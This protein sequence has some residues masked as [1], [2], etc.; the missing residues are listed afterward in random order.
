MRRHFQFALPLLALT[1]LLGGCSVHLAPKSEP[2]AQA[3]AQE[4]LNALTSASDAYRAED[5]DRAADLFL[6][7]S[8]VSSDPVLSR[9]ALYG[10]A[11]SKRAMAD[12]AEDMAEAM[13]VWNRWASLAPDNP[14]IEDPRLLAPLLPRLTPDGED[15]RETVRSMEK[16]MARLR[17]RLKEKSQD[18]DELK[19]QLD[20]LEQLHKEITIRKQDIN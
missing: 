3:Q 20:A 8:L 14:D 2:H 1:V 11:C 9:K 15:S 16:E 18:L 10:L 17:A 19:S 4:S 7:L 5:Y 13:E 12:T 6:A